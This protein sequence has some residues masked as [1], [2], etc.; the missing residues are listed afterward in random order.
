MGGQRSATRRRL[1][2]KNGRFWPGARLSA[3]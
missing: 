2:H 3:L 1:N